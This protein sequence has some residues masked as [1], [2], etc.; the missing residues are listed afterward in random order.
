MV[1]APVVQLAMANHKNKQTKN[2]NSYSKF[3]VK[4]T[5]K[6]GR[7]MEKEEIIKCFRESGGQLGTF[8]VL[9][10]V[11]NKEFCLNFLSQERNRGF[12]MWCQGLQNNLS[13]PLKVMSICEAATWR[14]SKTDLE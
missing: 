7:K 4:K 13:I 10:G 3:K 11:L 2:K 8:T 14:F 1:N 9:S 6:K 5:T 12:C